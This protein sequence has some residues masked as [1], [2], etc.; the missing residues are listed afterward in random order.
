MAH[1]FCATRDDRL[2]AYAETFR[3][4]G[5]AA[6][7]F[8]YR[9]FGASIGK[10]RQLL[11]IHRRHEDD[12]AVVAWARRLGGIDSDRTVLWGSSFNGGHVLAAAAGTPA[13]LP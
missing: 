3:D 1:G 7:L 4:T 11:D 6:V 12:R 2:P 9:H 5:F 10:P 13:S 8:D